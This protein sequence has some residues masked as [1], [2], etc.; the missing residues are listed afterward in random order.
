[1]THCID[2]QQSTQQLTCV[3]VLLI[4]TCQRDQA[5]YPFTLYKRLITT[6]SSLLNTV[7][8]KH[9][10]T[11]ASR[12]FRHCSFKADKVSKNDETWKFE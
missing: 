10:V 2:Q 5:L 7:I 8:C 4:P 3:P 9:R 6:L 1:M 12:H 11:S